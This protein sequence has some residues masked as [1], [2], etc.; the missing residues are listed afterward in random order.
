MGTL[1]IIKNFL[2]EEEQNLLTDYARIR[3]R[4]N[5]LKFNFKTETVDTFVYADPIMESLM[6]NKRKKIEDLINLDL[7]PTFTEWSLHTYGAVVSEYKQ[8]EACEYTC[9][10]VINSD[11]QKPWPI[12]IENQSI[13]LNNKDAILFKGFDKNYFRESFDGD[14]YIDVALHYVDKNGKYKQWVKDKKMNY[15]E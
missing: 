11:L 7:L 4:L 5:N 3:H 6:L 12:Y 9:Y 13:E 1:K 15:G 2:S 10:C 14:F 8:R